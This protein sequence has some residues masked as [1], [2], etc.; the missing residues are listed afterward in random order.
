MKKILLSL[1]LVNAVVLS[2]AKTDDVTKKADQCTGNDQ[3]ASVLQSNDGEKCFDETTHIINIGA[4]F[5][6]AY[7]YHAYRGAGWDYAATPAFSL[8]YEQAIPKHLGIGYVGVGAYF[9]FQHIHSRYDELYVYG[10]PYYYEHTWNNYM[11]AAR[12][13]YHF[14][15]LNSRRAEVYA[16]VIVGVRIQTYHYET[17]DPYD[18][19]YYRLNDGSVY[20]A[21]SL[22]AGARWYF[23]KNVALFGELGYGISYATGGFSFKF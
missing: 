4:G 14:D 2:Q 23:A 12:G 7:Y 8:T 3:C 22:F 16:G 15:V 17:N 11:I 10:N 13:A 18:N 21:A 19:G 20:P 1:L 9:G 5:G 6:S